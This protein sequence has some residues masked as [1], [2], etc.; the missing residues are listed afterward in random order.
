MQGSWVTKGAH[1]G[2]GGFLTEFFTMH[3]EHTAYYSESLTY[4]GLHNTDRPTGLWNESWVLVDRRPPRKKSA[5]LGSSRCEVDIKRVYDA[6]IW[7]G[8][9]SNAGLILPTCRLFRLFLDVL[10]FRPSARQARRDRAA[11]RI[12]LSRKQWD[13]PTA[14]VGS[15]SKCDESAGSRVGRKWVLW[16]LRKHNGKRFYRTTRIVPATLDR[17]SAAVS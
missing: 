6:V 4:Q 10:L 9:L 1:V 3:G 2:A 14:C 15:D 12:L 8:N 7:P 17:I 5:D 11:D 13:R 16:N